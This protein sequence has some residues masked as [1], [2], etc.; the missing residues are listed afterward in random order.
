MSE[1]A[2]DFWQ[3]FPRG[4]IGREWSEQ[5]FILIPRISRPTITS[6]PRNTCY[7]FSPVFSVAG[8]FIGQ[9]SFQSTI[10]SRETWSACLFFFF[11]PY[12]TLKTGMI[13]STE[14]SYSYLQH[15]SS[16]KL[17]WSKRIEFWNCTCQGSIFDTLVRYTLMISSSHTNS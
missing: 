4:L 16:W 2:N 1:I 10:H 6:W 17:K 14:Y 8:I 15:Q 11:F 9:K 5:M 3:H 13:L 7:P 12:G